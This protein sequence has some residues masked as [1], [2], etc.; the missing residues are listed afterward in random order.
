MMRVIKSQRRT[1]RRRL[2]RHRKILRAFSN[3]AMTKDD[4]VRQLGLRDYAELLVVLGA[5]GVPLP[6]LPEAEIARMADEFL[7]IWRN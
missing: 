4:A 5:C 6:R 7:T 2:R 1:A 3:R